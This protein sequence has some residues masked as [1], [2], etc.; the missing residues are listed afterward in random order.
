M[1]WVP[2]ESGASP[3]SIT[4]TSCGNAAVSSGKFHW[5]TSPDVTLTVF[6]FQLRPWASTSWVSGSGPPSAGSV[7]DSVTPTGPLYVPPAP[8]CAGSS[9]CVVTGAVVVGRADRER[10]TFLIASSLP[11]TSVERYSTVCSPSPS[12][13]TGPRTEP[14]SSDSTRTLRKSTTS[15]VPWFWSPM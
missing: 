8:G 5:T 11:A 13:V 15:G 6:G 10:V 12:T 14:S 9:A 3:G 1:T 7:A 2:A 4:H